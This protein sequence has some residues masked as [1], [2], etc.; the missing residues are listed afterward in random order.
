[1]TGVVRPTAIS[2]I[3]P[4]RTRAPLVSRAIDS[5]LSQN[6]PDDELIVVDDGSTDNTPEV[7]AKYG[8]RVKYIRTTNQGAGA[9]RNRGVR[10]ASRSLVAFLDSDDEW[11]PGHLLLLRSFMAARPELLFCFTNYASRFRD[12]SIRHF[13]LKPHDGPELD[14]HEIMGASRPV[15]S[16]IALPSG[17]Q[18]CMCF[19]GD[20]LYRSQ[21]YTSYVSVNTL[22][23]RRLEAGDNLRFAEDTP[24]AE[25]WECSA[26]LARAGIGVYLHCETA[27]VYHH[28]GQQ[29]IDLDLSDVASSRIRILRRVWGADPEFLREHDALYRQRLR[30]E[31]LLWIGRLLL[32]GNARDARKELSDVENAP[33]S[34]SLLAKLPGRLTK[35]LLD[36]RRAIKSL[37]RRGA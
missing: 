7:I 21:C 6:E 37:F 13:A 11:M 25:E 34:F 3:I 18:D 5:V 1:M 17:M 23:V 14:W 15:S 20:N 30:E 8:Q 29:L 24:T 19:E 35:G 9:A 36:S 26:R 31:Q 4:T 12:G 33:L 10:E 16:F 27:L 22:I 28:S 32:R 2:T